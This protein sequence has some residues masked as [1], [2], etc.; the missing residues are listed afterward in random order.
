MKILKNK[1][2]LI[3]SFYIIIIAFSGCSGKKA[4]IKPFDYNYLADKENNDT[5]S[6]ANEVTTQNPIV[7]F[8]NDKKNIGDK[9]YYKVYFSIKSTSYMI[10]LTGVPGIDSKL[11][12]YLPDGNQLFTIDRGGKGESEKLYE[13][14][15]NTDYIIIAVE[16]KTGYNEKVP[17]AVNFIPKMDQGINEIEP[18]NDKAS[19]AIIKLGEEKKGLISPKDDVD[20]YKI[21]FDDDNTHYFSIKIETLSNI[22]IS[23]TLMNQTAN[24][25]KFINSFGWGDKEFY[26]FLSNKK[27]EYYIKVSGS[28]KS[29][30]TKDPLYNLSVVELPNNDDGKELYYESEFNDNKDLATD[31]I[32]GTEVIG[33]LFP[34]NDEDWFKFD[35][36]KKPI[37]VDISLSKLKGV[38]PVIEVYD[39]NMKLLK[40]I[41][42]E[43]ED[44]GEKALLNDLG[45][46][47]Y[48]L[49]LF[50][51]NKKKSLQEYILFLNA[52]YK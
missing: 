15:P 52:R 6:K 13:Y 27:G 11:S 34:E 43:G 1:F 12:F 37:S 5:I 14:Y 40:V 33:A 17:Y 23:F 41:D 7:G 50:S 36:F 46:G 9:D 47:R 35:L 21:V 28:I 26:P 48:Y 3:Y 44:S 45:S 22:D 51:K 25:D 31:I 8:Y 18:N 39:S 32:N 2:I 10:V 49:K 29:N 19:A 24:I 38:D 4:D 42:Q 16:A 30:D 20:Y